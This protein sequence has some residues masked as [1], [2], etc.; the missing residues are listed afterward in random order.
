MIEIVESILGYDWGTTSYDDIIA[1]GALMLGLMSI[2]LVINI[3]KSIIR[4]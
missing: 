2:L 4:R 3:F 1:S